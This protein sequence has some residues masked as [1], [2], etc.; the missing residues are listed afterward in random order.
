[1]TMS[2]N[3]IAKALFVAVTAALTAVSGVQFYQHRHYQLPIVAGPS[4]T[5]VVNLSEYGKGLKG[6]MADTKVFFL[7]GKE[8]GGKVLIMAD[9]HPNESDALLSALIFI[10]N[11][12]VEKGTVIVIPQFN[13]SASRYTRPGDGYPLFFE[14]PT[15]WGAKKFRFGDRGA[16]PLDQW[17][18]PDV[19]IHYPDRQLLSFLDARNTNRSWP[20]RPNGLLME[21]V[22][23]AA[24]TLMKQ[25][26]VDIALDLHGAETMFPVTN[27]IVAPEKSIKI[28]TMV[29]M[30]VT[31]MEGFENH[32]EPS[33]KGFRG[34][35]HREI[36]DYSETLPF[37]ME[38][39]F[40]FLDQPTGPKTRDLLLSGKDPFLLSLA[41][42]QK[43]FVPYDESGWPVEKRV[44]QHCSVA[45]E[46][47]NQYS[48]KSTGRAIRL[49]NVPR[50]ADIVK[51]GVG[52]YFHDP[53]KARARDVYYN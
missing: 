50:Y 11:A 8:P 26:H 35:S 45:L 38:A 18:D 49:V 36:G 46:I 27:C 34:L 23:D 33:P 6:T 14:I 39:P 22:T 10:E 17:P 3:G 53:S 12:V 21:R 48:M 32:V 2:R 7:E 37:L 44:G 1:M 40:P 28:A 13:H 29:S 42:Q 52:F 24:M 16:A 31:A 30:T 51:N 47:I 9:T 4:V 20:G 5:R 41:G 19:Y 15:A 43:L 25:E